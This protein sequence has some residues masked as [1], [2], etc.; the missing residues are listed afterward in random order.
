MEENLKA[1][2]LDEEEDESRKGSF[3]FALNEDQNTG[4]S[5]HRPSKSLKVKEA[6]TMLEHPTLLRMI[7]ECHTR[8]ELLSADEAISLL[9]YDTRVKLW[10]RLFD[11]RN[12][13]LRNASYRCN[14]FASGEN[15]RKVCFFAGAFAQRWGILLYPMFEPLRLWFCR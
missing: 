8:N 4:Y 9:P 11:Y 3:F 5:F 1:K 7:R 12:S 15:Q 10:A 2:F 6:S 13:T 14:S